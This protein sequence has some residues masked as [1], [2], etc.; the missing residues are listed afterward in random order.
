MI[1]KIKHK[2]KVWF[3]VGGVVL[4][5]G[6]SLLVA[7]KLKKKKLIKQQE[8]LDLQQQENLKEVEKN[9]QGTQEA[10]TQKGDSIVPVR[11]FNKSINNKF[12]D[13]Y[14]VTLLPAKKSNNS[15]EGHIYA[16]GFATL[17]KTPEV[18]NPKGITDLWQS[19]I[20]GKIS[21]G[22]VIGKIVSEKYDNLDPPM[23]WFMVKL[24]KPMKGWN[25]AWVRADVVTF[26]P[27]VKGGKKSSSFIGDDMVVRYDNSYQL[28]AQVF[29]H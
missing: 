16:Q 17:R 24:V 29:P 13:I 20:I 21:A 19:N 26:N 27:F 12:T 9:I 3:I 1:N 7:N 10:N 11:N 6:I 15:I 14:G 2:N 25:Y 28:G 18:N 4:L 22:G 8:A 23:R 5:T